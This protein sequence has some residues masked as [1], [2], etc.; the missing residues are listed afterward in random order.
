MSIVVAYKWSAN[1][2]DAAVGADGVV[3]WSRAKAGV[4]EYDTVPIELGRSLAQAAE[5]EY[6]GISVGGKAVAT[7][8]AKKGAMSRGMDRGIVVADDATGDWNLS[9]VAG[10]LA[11]LARQ[12]EA[13]IVLTGDA[14]VDENAKMTSAVLA[15]HLGWPCF[16]EVSA[17]TPTDGGW[18]LTQAIP[19][20]TRTVEVTGGVVVAITS[21]AVQP[22]VAGMKEILAAGKKTVDVVDVADL[23]VADVDLQVTARTK[24]VAAARKHE[25][26]EDRTPP[27]N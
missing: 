4:S 3:D 13:E 16:Q 6:I 11:V 20:G 15:G 10:A 21:D 25:V 19:G 23:G 18:T 2:Q 9:Q 7:P 22:K 26:F 14:S 1:P 17:I 27:P 24:P 5:R 12:A 8:M